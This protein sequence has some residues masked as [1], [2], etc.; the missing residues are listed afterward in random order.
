MIRIDASESESLE[1]CGQNSN[2][3]DDLLI[4]QRKDSLSEGQTD[5]KSRW[6]AGTSFG[7]TVRPDAKDARIDDVQQR[8]V[9]LTEE[10]GRKNQ[11]KGEICADSEC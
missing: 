6:P 8:S 11:S 3:S 7:R 9:H 1:S 2:A 5:A 4:T 10:I